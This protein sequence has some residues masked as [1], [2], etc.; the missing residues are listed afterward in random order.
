MEPYYETLRLIHQL[1][2]PKLYVEVGVSHGD[3]IVLANKETIV[4]GIDPDPSAIRTSL[5][6]NITIFPMTSDDFFGSDAL[7]ALTVAPLDLAFIDGM[8]LFEYALRDFINLEKNSHS[9]TVV[10]VHD[11][12]PLDEHTSQRTQIPG[13]W[14]GDVWKL[15]LVLK[16]YRPDLRIATL[17]VA[18]TGLGTIRGL[19]RENNVLS[20]NYEEI[21]KTYTN[22]PFSALGDKKQ[23]LNVVPNSWA[24]IMFTT[25]EKGI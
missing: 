17:D 24:K 5:T 21:V 6:E 4:F 23:S 14:S 13:Y 3:S 7:K 19:D 8:H 2:K 25:E 20:E 1:T 16:K 22:L 15:I 10:L 18:P 11:C 9:G 12:L